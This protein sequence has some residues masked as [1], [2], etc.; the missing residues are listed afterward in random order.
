[1]ETE[2]LHLRILHTWRTSM[3]ILNN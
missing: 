1:M 2:I 3:F